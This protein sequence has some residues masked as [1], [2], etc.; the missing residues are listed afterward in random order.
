MALKNSFRGYGMLALFLI[1]LLIT[2]IL[3]QKRKLSFSQTVSQILTQLKQAGLSDREALFWVAVSRWETADFTS[4]L[5]TKYNNYFGMKWAKA[6]GVPGVDYN[7]S[8]WA[9]P[10]GLADS[11]RVQLGYMQRF[12]Y[13]KDFPNV[14][15]FVSFMKSKGYFQEVESEYLAGVKTKL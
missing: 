6:E 13:P 11:V 1:G 10:S 3:C 8:F 7:G 4:T 2:W 14:E 12:G 15:S 9:N 5:C